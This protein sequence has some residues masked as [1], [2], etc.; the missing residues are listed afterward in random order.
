MSEKSAVVVIPAYNEEKTIGG[1]VSGVRTH[2][3][4]ALVINDGSTDN[5]ASVARDA[6]ATVITHNTNRGYDETL[7]DGFKHAA[8]SDADIV[9]TFDAD[10]QHRPEDIPRVI[11]P[12]Q[13]EKAEIV[14]GRRPRPARA[15]ERLFALYTEWRL[16][17]DDPLSGFKAYDTGVY[18][19][20]GYFDRLSSIGTHLLVATAKLGYRIIQ[21]DIGLETRE[22]EPRFGH[23]K[24]NWVMLKALGRIISF[25]I[26][27]TRRTGEIRDT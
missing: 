11:E 22:D 19:D 23:L 9:V 20:V 17:I 6:G 12:I 8:E 27:T 2:V 24:A 15:A 7:S 10:D 16:G 18:R 13:N 25:D 26:R 4:S 14:V 3:D 21:V 1:V 5:T